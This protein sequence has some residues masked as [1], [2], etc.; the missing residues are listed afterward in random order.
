VPTATATSITFALSIAGSPATSAVLNSIQLIEVEDH[1]ELA[2]MLR[3]RIAVSVKD[4]GSGW[5]I[6]D[7]SMFERLTAIKLTVTVGSGSAITLFNGYVI[8]NDVEFSNQPNGSVMTVV[9]MDPTV[10]MHLEERVKAWPNMAHSDVA[11]AIFSGSAYGFTPVVQAT[12]YAPHEDDH[13][14]MQRGTD[15]QFLQ[16]LANANGYECYIDLDESSG[17]VQGHFHPPTTDDDPQSTMTVNMGSATNINRFRARYDMLGPTTASGTTVDFEQ[18]SNEPGQADTSDQ[19]SLGSDQSTS[20]DRPRKVLLSGLGMGQSAEVQRYAQSVVDRSS[21][22][23]TADGEL[24]TAAFGFV[25]RAKQP[26]TVRGVGRDFSGLY[27]VYKVV[28]LIS[29]DGNY[30]QRFTLRR[31]AVGLTGREQFREQSQ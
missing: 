21:W 19:N 22:A 4:S 12:N 23:I 6:V 26:V 28:H 10:L 27:Y 15:I 3:L 30:L 9:A 1:S 20:T 14:L 17:A 25:L 29:S 13:T 16:Q 31:N 2:D 8:E 18:K 7:D 11:S 24:N 5:T